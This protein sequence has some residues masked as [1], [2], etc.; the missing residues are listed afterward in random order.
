[1]PFVLDIFV[2]AFFPL[3]V[4]RRGRTIRVVENFFH[5]G[6]ISSCFVQFFQVSTHFRPLHSWLQTT[7]VIATKLQHYFLVFIDALKDVCKCF[8]V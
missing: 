1:M 4:V 6:T 3:K 5:S 2:E 7:K 8:E